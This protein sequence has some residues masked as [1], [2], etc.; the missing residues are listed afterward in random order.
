MFLNKDELIDLTG[1]RWKSRQITQLRKMGIPFYV[2]ASGHPV[3]AAS[4]IEG[5]KKVE[6]L[7]QKWTPKWVEIQA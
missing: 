6:P 1:C 7:T 5:K 4:V 2:N 3:V